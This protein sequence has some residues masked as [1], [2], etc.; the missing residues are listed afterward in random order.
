[1]V[2]KLFKAVRALW[3][4][5]WGLG[6]LHEQAVALLHAHV[7][8]TYQIGVPP[9]T[10]RK[11][12]IQVMN[13]FPPIITLLAARASAICFDPGMMQLTRESLVL[14]GE[15][16]IFT[17]KNHVQR[18]DASNIDLGNAT[19]FLAHLLPCCQYL[20]VLMLDCNVTSSILYAAKEC[21]LQVL[22]V[23][24]RMLSCPQVSLEALSELVLGVQGND[25]KI[26]LD[27]YMRGEEVTFNPSWPNL[28]NFSTGWC[29]VSQEFLILVLVVLHKMEYL[30]SNVVPISSVVKLYAN[31]LQN[32]PGLHK[33]ALKAN[34]IMYEDFWELY[35]HYPSMERVTLM[36]TSAVEE[37]LI[38]FFELGHHL[39]N[40]KMLRLT[41]V[42][43][44][45]PFVL[46]E[47]DQF[48]N[49]TSHIAILELDCIPSGEFDARWVIK[50]LQQFPC[51]RR[52]YLNANLIVYTE[53]VDP[54][55]T[56]FDT[57]IDLQ[58]VCDND[59]ELFLRFLYSFPNLHTLTLTAFDG[60]I[61]LPW[62]RLTELRNLRHL[63]MFA[64]GVRNING[65][66]KLPR[67]TSDRTTWEVRVAPRHVSTR[68]GDRLRR[69][70]WNFVPVN[71]IQL[72]SR[73]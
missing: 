58:C 47:G 6:Q 35:P 63:N 8:R 67:K 36:I 40:V 7:F 57:V 59:N 27:S 43:A 14:L 28:T 29:A 17:E 52:V 70:G 12:F 19:P 37:S 51:L 32:I 18:I 55:V 41:H 2:Q 54:W 33:L 56:V 68:Q 11:F 60:E 21:P 16:G 45:Y 72:T 44:Q 9:F 39:P 24:E 64:C 46:P 66:C 42:P 13:I 48:H 49:F 71:D 73:V 20:T 69:A 15:C 31:M 3:K 10:H 61:S 23:S 1:M 4:E 65:L 26:L 62:E 34:T 5:L 25:L 53:P 38:N 22:H 30:E 50:L